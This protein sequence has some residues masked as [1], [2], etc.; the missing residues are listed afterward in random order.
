[1][2]IHGH[3]LLTYIARHHVSTSY[4]LTSN[5]R[6]V[7]LY[8]VPCFSVENHV[9]F[10]FFLKKECLLA[11]PVYSPS[12]L[13]FRPSSPRPSRH[14]KANPPPSLQDR[15]NRFRHI[16]QRLTH[17]DIS[18]KVF[19]KKKSQPPCVERP[20]SKRLQ[21][22]LDPRIKPNSRTQHSTTERIVRTLAHAS[23]SSP[24]RHLSLCILFTRFLP[25]FYLPQETALVQSPCAH[26]IPRLYHSDPFPKHVITCIV[27][28]TDRSP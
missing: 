23:S 2:T 1:M 21:Y 8:S 10:H 15:L 26:S 19:P 6:N 12:H 4:H 14:Y 3:V 28:V 25:N 13:R 7:P 16:L 22:P 24:C 17:P 18:V 20:T 5:T 9:L 27:C 11:T